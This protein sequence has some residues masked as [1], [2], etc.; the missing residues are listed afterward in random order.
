MLTSSHM[1]LPVRKSQLLRK[2]DDDA[3]V[4]TSSMI[5]HWE[6]QVRELEA[7]RPKI[8]EDL[9][10][11]LS[12]G[13]FSENAEYQDAKYRLSRTDGRIFSLKERLKRAIVI[14]HHGT[15]GVVRLGSTVTVVVDGQTRVYHVVGPHETSPAHGR[16]SHV[17]PLGSALL[18]H[19]AGDSV[20]VKTP[21]GEM[22][23]AITS[24]K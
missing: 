19:Q 10:H 5:A 3:P 20:I 4:V 15:S 14:P 1:R 13:D 18:H 22:R 2:H 16:I 23:Y 6:D 12:L 7:Q 8:V 24:V 9:S 21:H 11:A 17:S